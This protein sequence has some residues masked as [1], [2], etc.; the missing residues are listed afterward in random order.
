MIKI[1][2]K[3]FLLVVLLVMGLPRLS[4]GVLLDF[5]VHYGQA[6]ATGNPSTQDF[7]NNT[8]VYDIKL[9]YINDDNWYL[10]ALYSLKNYST[11]AGTTNGKTGGVGL[12]YFFR[13]NFNFRAFYRHGESFGDYRE[14]SGFQAD[15]EYK[16][17]FASNFYIGALLSHRQVSY[18]TNDTILSYEEYTAKET[19]PAISVGFLIN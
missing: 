4:F 16:V 18:K 17:S 15:L 6:E 3:S 13:N 9:G 1:V 2:S 7:K 5:G 14:G 19:Y 11:L 10:G 8:S 12:G